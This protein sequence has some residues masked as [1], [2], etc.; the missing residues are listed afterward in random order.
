MTV[1]PAT[2]SVSKDI[3]SDPELIEIGPITGEKF[4]LQRPGVTI[5]ASRT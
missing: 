2:D 1:A 5:A 3:H 4:L